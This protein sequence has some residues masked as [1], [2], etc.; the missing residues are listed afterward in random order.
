M[1]RYVWLNLNWKN[2]LHF[3]SSV[4]NKPILFGEKPGDCVALI[5]SY[6]TRFRLIYVNVYAYNDV[7]CMFNVYIYCIR[8]SFTLLWLV[9][10]VENIQ[11][12]IAFACLHRFSTVCANNLLGPTCCGSRSRTL[13]SFSSPIQYWNNNNNM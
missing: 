7:I 2:N 12:S 9:Q 6:R 8:S 13:I 11:S 4:F 1:L 3:Y 5:L 10:R